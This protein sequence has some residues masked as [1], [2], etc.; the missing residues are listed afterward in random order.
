[1]TDD[2]CKRYDVATGFIEARRLRRASRQF[3]EEIGKGPARWLQKK[4]CVADVL[5]RA[6]DGAWSAHDVAIVLDLAPAEVDFRIRASVGFWLAAQFEDV[7][8]A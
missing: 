8:Q 6:M 4:D 5:A 2:F 1:M 7:C 3:W